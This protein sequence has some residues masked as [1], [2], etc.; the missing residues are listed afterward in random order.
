M[1]A[2]ATSAVAHSTI[3]PAMP[4]THSP[5]PDIQGSSCK[6]QNWAYGTMGQNYDPD[7]R[8]SS[9][10]RASKAPSLSYGPIYVLSLGAVFRWLD[11]AWPCHVSRGWPGDRDIPLMTQ[12]NNIWPSIATSHHNTIHREDHTSGAWHQLDAALTSLSDEKSWAQ[13][14]GH[15]QGP[16]SLIYTPGLHVSIE[17]LLTRQFVCWAG[18]ITVIRWHMSWH[19]MTTLLLLHDTH[20]RSH[21]N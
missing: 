4:Y 18:D 2:Y 14:N 19:H 11:P 15:S 5:I 6:Y 3:L 8:Q 12:Q 16:L 7:H 1:V 21:R 20:S 13:I 9:Q 10:S 17:L